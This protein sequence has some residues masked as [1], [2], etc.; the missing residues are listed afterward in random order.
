MAGTRASEIPPQK[1]INCWVISVEKRGRERPRN[2]CSDGVG[3]RNGTIGVEEAKVRKSRRS[4]RSRRWIYKYI[5]R[6]SV[7]TNA[8]NR[9]VYEACIQVSSIL[10]QSSHITLIMLFFIF[11]VI[12]R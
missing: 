11:Y 1:K 10:Q 4:T 2:N 12:L 6:G 9:N 8:Y 7:S 5:N 3:R